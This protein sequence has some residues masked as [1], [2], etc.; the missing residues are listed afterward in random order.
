M[1]KRTTGYILLHLSAAVKSPQEMN[2][3]TPKHCSQEET[4]LRTVE[5]NFF[6]E[7]EVDRLSRT[8]VWLKLGEVKDTGKKKWEKETGSLSFLPGTRSNSTLP[9]LLSFPWSFS[10]RLY[11][12]A[13]V[14]CS[15]FHTLTAPSKLDCTHT[16]TDFERTFLLI[17]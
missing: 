14:T 2:R 9:Q 15:P 8:L 7:G 6:F 17:R 16:H 10:R 12:F 13:K 5:E 1:T 11:L 3:R 4:K